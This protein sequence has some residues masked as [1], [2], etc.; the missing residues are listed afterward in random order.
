MTAT[1]HK[2]SAGDGFEYY[3]RQTAAHD[4]SERGRNSL[5]DYYSAKGESPGVWMGSGLSEFDS[6]AAGDE[7]TEKQMRALFGLGRHPDAEAI[8]DR[9][10]AER[11]AA[12]DKPGPAHRAALTASQLGQPFRIFSEASEFRRRCAEAFTAHNLARGERWNAKISDEVRAEIRTRIARELFA[13]EFDRAPLNDRELSGWIAHNSRNATTAVAGFDV[14]FSPVK[15]VSVLWAIAP[16]AI[17]ENIEAAHRAAVADALAFLES[18]AAYTRLGANGVAQ[19]DTRGLVATAFEHRESRADDPDLHTHVVISAKVRTREGG[20]WRALDA[21]M[22]YRVLVTASEVYNTRCEH[23]VHALVGSEFADRGDTDPDKR[24]IREI[25][26]VAESL[27]ELWSRRDAAIEA[28]LA[29]LARRFHAEWGREPTTVEMLKLSERATLDTRPAKHEL[30][31]RSEQRAIWRGEAVE[32]LSEDALTQMIWDTCHPRPAPRVQVNPEWVASVADRVIDIVS[33]KRSVWQF[34]HVRSEVE[35][36]IRGQVRAEDWE[37]AAEAVTAEALG[38]LRSIARTRPD[39]FAEPELLRRADRRSVY[40]V[41]GSQQ[42][43]SAAVLAAEHRLIAA[44]HVAGAA[45]ITD[46]SVDVAL[47]EY[48]ANNHGR[49]LNAGQVALVREFATSGRR[50]QVA[51]APAGTGKTVALQVLVRAWRSEGAAVLGLAPTAASAAVLEA[52]IGAGVPVNAIDKL[53]YILTHLTPE[54]AGRVHVPAWVHAIGPGTLVIIDEAAK[55]STWQLDL[56]VDFLLRRGAIVRAIGD[57]RQLASIT[58]G[59]V[60]RDIADTAGAVTLTR[61]MR[62][63]DRAEAAATLAVREGDPSVIAFYADR[64]RLHIGTLDRVVDACYTAWAD[65]RS[66]GLDAMMLAPTR[67]IVAILNQRA[68]ADRLATTTSEV[69]P[70]VELSDGLK[71]S[72]GDVICSRRNKPK[73]RISSTDYVRNGY[74]WRVV[75]ARADGSVVAAH[76]DSGRHVLLPRDYVQVEVTLGWATTIDSAQGITADAGHSVLTGSETRAQ[77]YVAISRGRRRNDIYAQTAVDLAHNMLSDRAMHPPTVVDILTETLARDTTQR[78]ATTQH[79]EIHTPETRLTHAVDAY[80]YALGAAAEHLAGP[81]VMDRIDI[82]SEQLYPGLTDCGGWPALRQH[83]AIIAITPHA[84]GQPG[85]P[86]QRLA[87]AIDERD[88]DSVRDPAAV[89]DWRLDHSDPQS[90]GAGPLPWL[91]GIPDALR[92]HPEFG[93]Y[94]VARARLVTDLAAQIRRRIHVWTPATAPA[95]A[96]PLLAAPTGDSGVVGA[97]AVWRA[98]RRVDDAD[99]RPTG[100]TLPDFGSAHRHQRA[101]DARVTALVGDLTDTL[102]KWVPA[103]D[104]I[105]SRIAADAFWPALAARLDLAHRAE[106]TFPHY[107]TTPPSAARCLTNG[108]PPPCGGGWSAISISACSTPTT[109]TSIHCGQAG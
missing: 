83:L 38:P 39:Q 51:I 69:G 77:L 10:Y 43:T 76:L 40:T 81:E 58:A 98:A 73:L 66:A 7:V 91:I 11:L 17:A 62:F 52:E 82:E 87:A 12:G 105:D 14:C 29:E 54:T 92:D 32:L 104:A 89:L 68:R 101:L 78:S 103:V 34:T 4:V 16:R 2:L 8:E 102:G 84:D 75:E 24:P 25:V 36:Q 107:Y 13:A 30:R 63:H 22:V 72:A 80:A 61:V 100:P 56:V 44:A 65:D 47:L 3:L 46:A 15:S 74:R 5:A 20:L 18:H 42:Y 88:F 96:R 48:T 35:R 21:R 53:G 60:L 106:S 57:D 33:R 9:V 97:V 28:R 95:W 59:G 45:T 94:L 27:R 6:I 90:C 1:V 31:S 19:V 109:A 26:G 99:H 86:L 71:A 41:A 23:H 67:E 64:D 79:R 85:D 49:E 50:L 70:E 55:A 93:P 37:S 108:P